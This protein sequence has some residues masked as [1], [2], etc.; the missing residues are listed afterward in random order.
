[1]AL[2]P[3]SSSSVRSRLY[4]ALQSSDFLSCDTSVGSS[5]PSTPLVTPL[6]TPLCPTLQPHGRRPRSPMLP[7]TVLN[8]SED[9]PLLS[10]DPSGRTVPLREEDANHPAEPLS[11]PLLI[12]RGT[13]GA[14]L[15]P[16]RGMQEYQFPP[17]AAMDTEENSDSE[18]EEVDFAPTLSVDDLPLH[19]FQMLRHPKGQRRDVRGR[20][21]ESDAPEGSDALVR[22][23]HHHCA[24][25]QLTFVL[26]R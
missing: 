22:R 6:V 1:M 2:T 17:A 23:M 13:H 8:C 26:R 18:D 24:R 4:G 14:C 9:R 3:A 20:S 25:Q 5:G 16:P 19:L 15:S 11:P 21:G 10:R 7:P 12:R